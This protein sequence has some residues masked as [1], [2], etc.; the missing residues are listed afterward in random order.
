M[1]DP[2][3]NLSKLSRVQ[4]RDLQNRLLHSFLNRQVYPFSSFYRNLFDQKRIDPRKIKTVEDLKHIPLTSKR[5]FLDSGKNADRFRDFIL[6]PDPKTIKKYLP[7]HKL[8]S[9]ALR[10][11][12]QGKQFVK[13]EV[14]KEYRPVFITFT[15]GTTERP[16]PYVYTKH[17]INNLSI[18]GSRMVS[19]FGIQESEHI[20]N[21][22]PY[23]PHLAFWQVVFGG[24]SSGIL[25]L[26][27]GG[28]KVSGTEASIAALLKMKPAVVLGVPSYLYHI[29]RAAKEKGCDLSFIK[30][31]VLGA[32]RIPDT[33]KTRVTELLCSLGSKDPF[34]FGT[35]GFTEA[36]TAWAEC[37]APAGVSSGYHLYPDKEIFE[38]IDPQTGEIKRE[39]EDGELVYTSI[40]SRGSAVIRYRTGDFVKGGITYEPCPFCRRT[41]P[42]ISSNITRMSDVRSLKLSKIKGTLVDLNSFSEILEKFEQ[43]PEWQIEI[44]KKDNDP[45]EIDEV[46]VYV[47]VKDGVDKGQIEEAIKK[48]IVLATE[49][50]PNAV[51]FISFDEMVRRLELE[52]SSKEKRIIDVRPK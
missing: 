8:A 31:V 37:P 25:I 39:G 46:I 34:I 5:D 41:V 13:D 12:L 43:I 10:S 7:A 51:F 19:L 33:F 44:R 6:Q 9:M 20:V 47:C 49:I 23:A 27:T 52:T 50:T 38:V 45:F 3:K 1:I 4:V 2:W 48:N 17:D 18:S 14:S 40:D 35:Y 16:L 32:S 42:R 15:T 24:L 22:F 29:L 21:L 11:V 26:S 28:G 30:K 36:R